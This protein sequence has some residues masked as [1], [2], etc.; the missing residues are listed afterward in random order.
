MKRAFELQGCLVTLSQWLLC[1]YLTYYNS[2]SSK[3]PKGVKLALIRS[4]FLTKRQDTVCQCTITGSGLE[5]NIVI[6]P[7]DGHTILCLIGYLSLKK[8]PRAMWEPTWRRWGLKVRLLSPV[9]T[10]LTSELQYYYCLVAK[11]CFHLDG[12]TCNLQITVT[13]LSQKYT[14]CVRLL[15]PPFLSDLPVFVDQPHLLV[16]QSLRKLDTAYQAGVKMHV[17]KM[18]IWP[19]HLAQSCQQVRVLERLCPKSPPR[20]D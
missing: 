16:S 14:S 2:Y 3:V 12:S 13:P 19:S 10:T 15:S 18:K 5:K 4:L 1:Q 11:T 9:Q 17:D 20:A 7:S 6:I 8:N